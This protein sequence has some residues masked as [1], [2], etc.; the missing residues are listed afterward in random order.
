MG[1]DNQKGSSTERS[2][3]RRAWVEAGHVLK[4]DLRAVW[5]T[6]SPDVSEKRIQHDATWQEMDSRTCLVTK[7]QS[8][9]RLPYSR[10]SKNKKTQQPRERKKILLQNRRKETT[11]RNLL[12]RACSRLRSTVDYWKFRELT[13]LVG[14]SGLFQ[15]E[16]LGV[17]KRGK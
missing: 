11:R 5:K 13:T 4:S 16:G 3:C 9:H 6:S 10:M 17:I 12:R 2:Y 8:G 14:P 15:R 1:W 7:L